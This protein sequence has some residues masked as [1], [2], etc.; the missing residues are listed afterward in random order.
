MRQ[1]CT[2]ARA[3]GSQASSAAAA[4]GEMWAEENLHGPS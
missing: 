2:C 1:N 3:A 4:N